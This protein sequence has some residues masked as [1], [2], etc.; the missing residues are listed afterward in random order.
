VL[1]LLYDSAADTPVG[2]REQCVH[3]AHRRVPRRFDQAHDVREHSFVA[4]LGSPRRGLLARHRTTL[5]RA[6]PR[7]QGRSCPRSGKSRPRAS[8]GGAA[9][10]GGEPGRSRRFLCEVARQGEQQSAEFTQSARSSGILGGARQSDANPLQ[11]RRPDR[12]RPLLSWAAAIPGAGLKIPVSAVR[13][14]PWAL[15][16]WRNL[17]DRGSRSPCDRAGSLVPTTPMLRSPFRR[18]AT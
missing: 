3:R 7:Q 14:R 11:R 15:V 4:G 12:A 13:F 5:H 6:R 2:R 10:S 17:S 18:L 8:V 16:L 1:L 9:R